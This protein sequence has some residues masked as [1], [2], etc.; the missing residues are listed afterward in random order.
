MKTVKG[1]KMLFEVIRG[2]RFVGVS[3]HGRSR[4]KR[5]KDDRFIE[6]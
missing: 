1:H 3:S 6:G 5:I 4:E 2:V